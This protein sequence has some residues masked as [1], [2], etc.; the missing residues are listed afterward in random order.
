MLD[1]KPLNSI[2]W[3]VIIV[4]YT[5]AILLQIRNVLPRPPLPQGGW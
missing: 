1:E 2:T 4:I 5:A 3:Q